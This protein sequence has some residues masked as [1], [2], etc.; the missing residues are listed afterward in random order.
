MKRGERNESIH[1]C[2]TER[3]EREEGKKRG[4]RAR[5]RGK[6]R[7]GMQTLRVF[8]GPPIWMERGRNLPLYFSQGCWANEVTTNWAGG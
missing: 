6:W 4:E 1:V 5:E 7:E 3:E 8:F 2:S